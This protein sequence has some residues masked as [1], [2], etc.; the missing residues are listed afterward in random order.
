MPTGWPT[1][2]GP[3]TTSAPLNVGIGAVT[4]GGVNAGVVGLQSLSGELPWANGTAIILNLIVQV[5]K[6]KLSFLQKH[7]WT[8]LA[9]ML[10]AF[11]MGYFV[12]F[13]GDSAKALMNMGYSVI[14]ALGNYKGDKASGLN[15]LPAAPSPQ[16]P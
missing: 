12:I 9:M 6:K 15:I 5:F 16:A 8:I 3:L 1:R 10:I 4:V 7:E 2:A 14:T 11:G 13:H